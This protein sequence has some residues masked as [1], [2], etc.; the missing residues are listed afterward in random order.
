MSAEAVGWVFRH[1]PY[2][3]GAFAIHVALAD[4][5]NDLY[6]NQVWF[7]VD[8]LAAK[9]RVG[10]R[11]VIAALGQMAAGSST[12]GGGKAARAGVSDGVPDD[13]SRGRPCD[14]PGRN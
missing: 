7:G 11:T 13:L 10:R 12:R 14:L 8:R 2:K 6:D 3:H 1:S 9:A 5:A 4:T